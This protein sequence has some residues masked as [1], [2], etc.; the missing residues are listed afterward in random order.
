MPA[1]DAVFADG[2][3]RPLGPV[4]LPENQRVKLTVEP[5][6]LPPAVAEWLALAAAHRERLRAEGVPVI[7][8]TP[9]IAE[10]R[11]RVM[12]TAWSI[13]AWPSNGDC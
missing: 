5:A 9:V 7:D 1:I 3:F 2:V 8:S 13:P 6:T 12:L 11:R 4:G 10:G